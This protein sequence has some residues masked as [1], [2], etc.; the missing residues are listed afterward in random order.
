[1][2]YNGNRMSPGDYMLLFIMSRLSESYSKNKIGM[3]MNRDY[4]SIIFLNISSQDSWNPMDR[5]TDEKM[6]NIKDKIK[7]KIIS[8][9]Y[10]FKNI[11]FDASNIA[12]L[13]WKLYG[14]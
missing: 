13:W 4:S 2:K 7:Y 1:M 8:M 14:Q 9:S 5:F 11:F 3:W 10:D 6:K 12:H